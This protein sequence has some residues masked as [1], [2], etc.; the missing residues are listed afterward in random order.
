M[1]ATQ[2]LFAL[3]AVLAL[4]LGLWAESRYL[5]LNEKRTDLQHNEFH[6]IEDA[7]GDFID[8]IETNIRDVEH[9][10]EDTKDAL[11]FLRRLIHDLY[12]H[13]AVSLGLSFQGGTLFTI[14]TTTG[15]ATTQFTDAHGNPT[16]APVDANGAPIVPTVVSDDT[17]VLTVAAGVAGTEGQY[18]FAVTPV[19]VGTA[20]LSVSTL[21]L[22]DGTPFPL[23]VPVAVTVDAA[24]AASLT[25]TFTE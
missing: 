11:L 6:K 21:T 2:A 8:D 14:D 9:A 1:T 13:P 23:P 25:L 4:G 17:A 20:N 22:A 19:A 7:L 24:P 18:T 3:T 12:Q 10:L 16:N 15:V 5:P